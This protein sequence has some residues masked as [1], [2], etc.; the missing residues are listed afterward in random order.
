MINF[1]KSALL[2]LTLVV[3][4]SVCFSFIVLGK[5]LFFILRKPYLHD[6]AHNAAILWGKGMFYFTPGWSV[7]ITGRENLTQAGKVYIIV[8]NHESASDIFALYL[9]GNQFRW[10]SKIEMFKV[11]VIGTAMTWAGYV[12]VTR[13]DKNSRKQALDDSAK[14]LQNQTPMLFFPEG[15]RS[16]GGRPQ[17]FKSGA[18]LLAKQLHL[19]VLPI[20]L[21]GTGKL[22]RKGTITPN[23]AKIHIKVLPPSYI[24]AG[25]DFDGF[26]DRVEKLMQDEHSRIEAIVNNTTATKA[27]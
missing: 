12:P 24:Q 1:L 25:E 5:I 17:N 22:L 3:V 19:P 2:L 18:F 10:L 7:E 4:T 21:Y 15:T 6:Y 13:H 14:V 16:T 26:K 23:K 27:T 11:P 9:L 8:A 20:V